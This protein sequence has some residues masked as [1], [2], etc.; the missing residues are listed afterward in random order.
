[1][2][3]YDRIKY[4]EIISCTGS[5][6][7]ASLRSQSATLGSEYVP[8]FKSIITTKVA[9]YSTLKIYNEYFVLEVK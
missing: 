7:G 2:C 8:P 3:F 6:W 9:K 1:M 5:A 4:C